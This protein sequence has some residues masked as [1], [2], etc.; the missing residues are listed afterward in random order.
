MTESNIP[1]MR[2]SHFVPS[3]QRSPK[4][5]HPL[6]SVSRSAS[7]VR[8]KKGASTA[9]GSASRSGKRSCTGTTP[10]LVPD[11]DEGSGGEARLSLLTPPATPSPPGF[12]L[13]QVSDWGYKV[14]CYDRTPEDDEDDDEE[15]D[16]SCS[17]SYSSYREG[18]SISSS[19][20]RSSFAQPP[21]KAPLYPKLSPGS[22]HTPSRP[23]NARRASAQCRAIEGYVSFANVEGLGVPPDDA[24]A[25]SPQERGGK[26][27]FGWGGGV[28]RKILGGGGEKEEGAVAF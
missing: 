21:A 11:D 9:S 12:G 26:G 4:P 23:F 1:P 6:S 20:L 10:P 18:S 25:A 19:A 17:S 8:H 27:V 15:D 14:R 13:F 5:S 22:P 7:L 3:P 28:V 2:R 16:E 24:G